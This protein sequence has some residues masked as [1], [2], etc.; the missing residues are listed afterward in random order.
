MICTGEGFQLSCQLSRCFEFRFRIAA[1]ALF[2][3]PKPGFRVMLASSEIDAVYSCKFILRL[4]F[5]CE[6]SILT[7]QLVL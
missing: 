6:F 7:L 4:I 3:W 2:S 5:Y 1:L